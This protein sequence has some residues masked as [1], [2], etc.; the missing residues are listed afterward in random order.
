[1][2]RI[3]SAPLT[4]FGTAGVVWATGC[5][6]VSPRPLPAVLTYLTVATLAIGFIGSRLI[7]FVAL[8]EAAIV[9]TFTVVVLA[10]PLSL[11]VFS[12]LWTSLVFGSLAFIGWVATGSAFLEFGR[13][14]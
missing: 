3:A 5:L 10:G 11:G 1:M 4:A 7:V 14:H 6:M 9:L 13:D 2:Q 12:A 8:W